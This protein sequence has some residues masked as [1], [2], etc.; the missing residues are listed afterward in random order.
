MAAGE[1]RRQLRAE[2]VRVAAREEQVPA[3]TVQA[4]DKEFPLGK[5][6][7]FIEK[8][9]LRV[10]VKGIE[11][12]HQLIV[13][14]QAA[15]PLV[16]EVRITPTAGPGRCPMQRL[17][18]LP[19]PARP[20]H[21]PDSISHHR[22]DDRGS[23]H[24]GSNLRRLLFAAL[25]QQDIVEIHAGNLASKSGIMQFF[26]LFAGLSPRSGLAARFLLFL[27]RDRFFARGDPF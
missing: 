24:I 4:V 23:R 15:K 22:L 7:D 17:A 14:L 20:H 27:G 25:S 12:N 2:Q 19:R 10:P 1:V 6:L 9:T 21:H 5:V 18:R 16:I 13:V 3:G 11:R 26:A 8:E